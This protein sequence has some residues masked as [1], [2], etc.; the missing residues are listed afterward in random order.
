MLPPVWVEAFI[1]P[2]AAK[3]I[4]FIYAKCILLCQK[5]LGKAAAATPKMH[6]QPPNWAL[7]R[8]LFFPW[9]LHCQE[10]NNALTR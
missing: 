2:G 6:V 4:E 9:E 5:P 10:F 8:V 3:Y 7:L 1:T